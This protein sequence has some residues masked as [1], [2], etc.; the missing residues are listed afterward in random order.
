MRIWGAE[1]GVII[2]KRQTS[3]WGV[4]GAALAV[5]TLIVQPVVTITSSPRAGAM[6]ES[7]LANLLQNVSPVAPAAGRDASIIAAKTDDKK[8]KKAA[9]MQNQNIEADA[10]APVIK[11]PVVFSDTGESAEDALIKGVRTFK[12]EH[13]AESHPVYIK[14][15]YKEQVTDSATN[16]MTWETK[17]GREYV[18]LEIA[19]GMVYFEVDTD[20]A[21]Y[22]DGMHQI[23]IISRSQAGVEDAHTFIVG[24]DN[25]EPSVP[26]V[27]APTSATRGSMPKITGTAEVGT[28]VTVYIDGVVQ[29]GVVTVADDGTWA[30]STADDT[31]DEA[32]NYKIQAVAKD[33]AGNRS[34]EIGD[35]ENEGLVVAV[36]EDRPQWLGADSGGVI[37]HPLD[38][39]A[40]VAPIL[41]PFTRSFFGVA[42]DDLVDSD[43]P[44][45]AS[46]V[47]TESAILGAQD[48]K[49]NVA[50][51]SKPVEVSES[52]WKLFGVAWFWYVVLFAGISM[53]LWM[54]ATIRRRTAES[55]L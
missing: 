23:A 32:R 50:A 19:D 9:D 39:V 7:L 38:T 4:V 45:E 52:G 29:P 44:Q 3:I 46:V 22:Q 34:K 16:E 24:V 42:V 51:T 55:A 49:K 41:N 21:T 2:A 10:Q 26:L 11:T 18:G 36:T 35:Q 6:T 13:E 8:D 28:E 33:A 5:A 40:T 27:A 20:V 43:R 37:T 31:F 48:V 15:A 54:I 12:I 25:T 53:V 47:P 30:Y 14:A 1:R 17:Y